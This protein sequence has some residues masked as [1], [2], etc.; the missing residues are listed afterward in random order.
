MKFFTYIFIIAALL[1][2]GCGDNRSIPTTKP[3]PPVKAWVSAG[4]KSM[5]PTYPE[6]SMVEVEFGVPFDE[7]KEGTD[8]VIYWAYKN[9]N[10]P[11]VFHRLT[12][13]VGDAFIAQGDN[14]ETNPQADISWVT[15]DNYIARATGRHSQFVY[16]K[17]P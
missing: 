8:V 10:A 5:L 4:G 3:V 1:L 7:L 13:K 9:P 6:Y 15:R 16:S 14:P 2:S 11:M 12:K 17:V